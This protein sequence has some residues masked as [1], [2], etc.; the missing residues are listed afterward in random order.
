[1]APRTLPFLV[2]LLAAS[3]ADALPAELQAQAT[4]DDA[5][6]TLRVPDQAI[7]GDARS[8]CRL[9]LEDA[10]AKVPLSA[11]DTVDLAVYEDDLAGDDLIWQ[12]FYTVPEDGPLSVDFDC[13]ADFGTDVGDN[14]ELYA[15]A[16][17]HKAEC[18]SWCLNDSPK[19]SNLHV[20]QVLDDPAEEDDSSSTPQPV[21]FGFAANRVARDADW[22]SFTVLDDSDVVIDVLHDPGTG[23]L[24][25]SL[26]EAGG[27]VVG[28]GTPLD[29]RTRIE[30]TGIGAGQLMVVVWPDDP[31]DFNFY[32]LSISTS[33]TVQK[34]CTP[35]ASE[36]GPC[37]TCGLR[38]RTCR[39][40]GSWGAWSACGGEGTCLPGTH[41]VKGCGRCGSRLL[42]C[43]EQCAWS[44]GP[45][46]GEGVC[47]PGASETADCPSGGTRARSC[48]V[49]CIWGDW[50]TCATAC[51]EGKQAPCY[52][53]PASTAG[54]GTCRTGL[55]SCQG[56]VWGPCIGDFVPRPE[57]C[58]NG[59]DDDCDGKTD[60]DDAD[61]VD[62]YGQACAS[63]AA[64]GS[65][66]CL[67]APAWP[68]FSTGSCGRT[69][70]GPNVPCPGPGVC[71][72]LF[73]TTFC[74]PD[75]AS[76]HVCRAGQTC[77]DPGIGRVVCVPRCTKDADCKAPWR[78]WCNASTGLCETT[79]PAD[80]T[81]A[82]AAETH[83]AKDVAPEADCRA[84][85]V[86]LV[87]APDAGSDPGAGGAGDGGCTAGAHGAG[88]LAILLML[89]TMAFVARG[90]R[91]VSRRRRG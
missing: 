45:C 39:A 24:N 77:T 67:G 82:D 87:G 18:G 58:R 8:W 54:V 9:R 1:M 40:D 74:L 80:A 60:S 59:L 73:D 46:V 44:D 47:T 69:G 6:L 83:E 21:F 32:D 56:G 12:A 31:A 37:G 10:A 62:R 79:A 85:D 42:E 36:N 50:G 13:S 90:F 11:G 55:K 89:A 49:A 75:C 65:L 33:P 78:P 22:A 53:G 52:T 7:R 29:D 57:D 71:A 76:T 66:D 88:P 23:R 28:A 70:C 38:Q 2:L 14:L 61:C 81:A 41:D 63:D 64:C 17:V 34:G 51:A 3:T 5:T 35:S 15:Q 72:P 27:W 30:A 84:L 20:V 19:T 86:V 48:T 68:V 43:T 16:K 4:D 26:I 91:P 25:A